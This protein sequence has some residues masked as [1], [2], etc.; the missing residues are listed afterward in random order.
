MLFNNTVQAPIQIIP[1]DGWF[2][3]FESDK[4]KPGEFY[5]LPLVCWAFMGTFD[6]REGT[7]IKVEDRSVSGMC[8]WIES[9]AAFFCSEIEGFQCYVHISEKG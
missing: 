8:I 3:R 6:K 7:E 5:D 4:G 9:G 2:A 1:A